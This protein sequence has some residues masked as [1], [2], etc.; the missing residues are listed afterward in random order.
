[1]VSRAERYGW[2]AAF[3]LV[4]T[5][6]VPWFLWGDSRTALG[7]PLWLC[8]HVG[9]MGLAAVVFRLFTKRAWDAGVEGVA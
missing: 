3:A 9:W 4:V 6:A 8:W 2:V 1:M 7:L 5:F